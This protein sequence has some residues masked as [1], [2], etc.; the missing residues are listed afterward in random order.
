MREI[1]VK[2]TKLKS[3][4]TLLKGLNPL[5]IFTKHFGCPLDLYR[6]E[7]LY[8]NI[9]GI[10]PH[11]NFVDYLKIAYNT[12]YGIVIKPDFI[13]YTIL[14][15]ISSLVNNNPDLYR[16]YFT[17]EKE[18]KITLIGINNSLID[19]PI[20]QFIE[21]VLEN[22][23]SKLNEEDIIP[24]F[25][26]KDQDSVIA[27]SVAFL[28]TV[29]SY[30]NYIWIGCDYN[31]LKIMGEKSDY[32]LMLT[33]LT[34]LSKIEPLKEYLNQAIKAVQDI[35]DNYNS[36]DF[37]RS[38]LWTSKGYGRDKVDGW[39]KNLFVEGKYWNTH[40]SKI[41]AREATKDK[42]FVMIVGL[43]S[44][45][46]KKGYMIPHFE[47]I[48][49]EKNPSI[50]SYTNTHRYAPD[51]ENHPLYDDLINMSEY[52]RENSMNFTAKVGVNPNLK[53]QAK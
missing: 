43:L 5:D 46:V 19:M 21:I 3:F 7:V 2:N 28:E 14:C 38:I 35:L 33:S 4:K 31:K 16:E 45:E 52:D 15:E 44:S 6:N 37:W 40:L 20:E 10:V 49:V 9:K 22:I 11:N 25:T 1:I 24:N 51:D 39:I 53:K 8:H 50:E 34:N 47:R 48:I 36:D 17:T 13:W 26:T 32:E 42:I 18:E 12:D 30:Y 27:F 29:S 23:P 41:E